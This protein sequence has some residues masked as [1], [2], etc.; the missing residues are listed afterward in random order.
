MSMLG[1][2]NKGEIILKTILEMLPRISG[3]EFKG[4]ADASTQLFDVGLLDSTHLLDI[5]LEVEQRCAVKFDPTRVEF[6]GA[7][8][9]G[10]LVSAFTTW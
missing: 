1:T 2:N 4:G 6:E 10:N 7:L 5:I 3:P 8:T 9:L